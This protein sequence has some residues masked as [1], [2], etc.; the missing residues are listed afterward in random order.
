MI[1][2]YNISPDTLIED[3]YY[4]T[5]IENFLDKSA[6]LSFLKKEGKIIAANGRLYKRDKVGFLS[7]ILMEMFKKRNHFKQ[8]QSQS[9][10]LL[11][12]IDQEI[13]KRG[14]SL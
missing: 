13:N 1:A 2:Q 11:E 8:L 5:P 12:K 6:D 7:E 14:L 3:E 9:Q 4:P 10:K